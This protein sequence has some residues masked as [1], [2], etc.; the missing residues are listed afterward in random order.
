MFTVP[1]R[2]FFTSS[3]VVEQALTE[4]IAGLA[5]VE[6]TAVVI[7]VRTARRLRTP[8][9]HL[10][11]GAITL[12]Y[13]IS[14]TSSEHA[15][16]LTLTMESFSFDFMTS[17][18]NAALANAGLEF[19]IGAI[20]DIGTPSI[21][22]DTPSAGSITTSGPPETASAF[23]STSRF[24]SSATASDGVNISTSTL[25]QISTS[26]FDNFT[27]SIDLDDPAEDFTVAG[28]FSFSA[29]NAEDIGSDQA[30]ME[31]VLQESIAEVLS[32]ES[33]QVLIDELI[34]TP[35]MPVFRRRLQSFGEFSVV[36]RVSLE[37]VSRY[38]D[39]LDRMRS[40]D[41]LSMELEPILAR[42][43]SRTVEEVQF[44]NFA[45]P[46]ALSWGRVETCGFTSC[47]QCASNELGGAQGVCTPCP[48]GQQ[49]AG[50]EC[51]ACPDGAAGTDGMCELCLNGTVPTSD[52]TGCMRGPETPQ[53][54]TSEIA[55][56]ATA[57]ILGSFMLAGFVA[58]GFV[59]ALRK[60]R[61]KV[62][63]DLLDN[64]NKL[65]E[66]PEL[67]VD[68]E[69]ARTDEAPGAD[70]PSADAADQPESNDPWA[71]VFPPTPRGSRDQLD[72]DDVPEE[73]SAPAASSADP[74]SVVLEWEA[75]REEPA[76]NGEWAPRCE[77][78]KKSRETPSKSLRKA[79]ACDFL[80]RQETDAW[81]VDSGVEDFM[82][83]ALPIFPGGSEHGDDAAS[84]WSEP[85]FADSAPDLLECPR[86]A[87]TMD[88]L[89]V[90]EN[91]K[92]PEDGDGVARQLDWE[93][94]S[95]VSNGSL[96]SLPDMLEAPK[97]SQEVSLMKGVVS[98]G[99]AVRPKMPGVP[100]T[101]LAAPPGWSRRDEMG[102][103]YD[104]AVSPAAA[105]SFAD[106]ELRDIV[107]ESP[108]AS[109][110]FEVGAPADR[111]RLDE[112]AAAWPG[113]PDAASEAWPLH[114]LDSRH[115]SVSSD[116]SDSGADQLLETPKR[117][118]EASLMASLREP[119]SPGRLWKS[120]AAS[121]VGR[122]TAAIAAA[123]A[124]SP[125][126]PEGFS[127]ELLSD[128]EGIEEL[129]PSDGFA[130]FRAGGSS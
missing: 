64:P 74:G 13:I 94:E 118:P 10:Q 72:G 87:Q 24:L 93:V 22:T 2:A 116:A 56:A 30:A 25:Q 111:P 29:E 92:A 127:R 6:T 66:S 130:L 101:P 78:P 82:D 53:G 40:L 105:G 37:E 39:V 47:S 85:S 54:A 99:G 123:M 124:A 61:A 107:L 57:S 15:E 129:R 114:P 73:P 122:S 97:S 63:K 106:A 65:A 71:L 98:L 84:N 46:C 125:V 77:S 67:E 58:G 115:R 70:N 45:C 100:D 83:C 14:A 4:A 41:Q 128:Q 20:S 89:V 119:T 44:V 38:I 49:P 112:A 34:F 62:A 88:L 42:L 75:A 109:A 60:R 50:A 31:L 52:H 21:V 113:S 26:G 96:G 43:F 32:V 5:S 69:A 3:P 80:G 91:G 7:D 1:D 126:T 108:R 102:N 36:F 86:S 33:G 121:P 27:T 59:L 51:Q 117:A 81:D 18:I 8:A 23:T 11:E 28:T 48:S 110:S 35:L 16:T 79:G 95:D 19:A 17:S 55:V 120:S 103:P 90:Q 68:Q 76:E 12:T 104:F 9:R